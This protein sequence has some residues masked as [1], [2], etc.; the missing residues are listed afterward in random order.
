MRVRHSG[1]GVFCEFKVWSMVVYPDPCSI[2]F[3]IVL[4]LTNDCIIIVPDCII[5][6]TFKSNFVV[7]LMIASRKVCMY[8]LPMT[9]P[10]N[11]ASSR[12]R[13]FLRWWWWTIVWPGGGGGGIPGYACGGGYPPYPG[14]GPGYCG[15][16]PYPGWGDG[17]GGGYPGC[18]DG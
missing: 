8:D 10:A 15:G 9:I 2:V 11:K 16:G 7:K 3:Y 6:V 1:L 4:Y 13:L 17:C 14:C 12:S 18:G 5:F